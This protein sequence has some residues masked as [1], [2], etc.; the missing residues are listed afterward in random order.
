MGNRRNRSPLQKIGSFLLQILAIIAAIITIVGYAKR[1]VVELTIDIV[2]NAS[3]FDL[4]QELSKLHVI[5]DSV[6]L[7]QN[8]LMLSV[9]LVRFNNT[10]FNNIQKESFDDEFPL[11]VR[12][13]EGRIIERPEIYEASS[14]YLLK[15]FESI[16]FND[17]T[18][19]IPA[20]HFD[21]NE[22][23]SINLLVLHDS[24]TSPTLLATGK[25][26]GQRELKVLYSPVDKENHIGT[27]FSGSIFIHLLR[28]L[29]YVIV[30]AFVVLIWNALKNLYLISEEARDRN[31]LK[32][33]IKAFKMSEHYNGQTAHDYE[34]IFNRYLEPVF[35]FEKLERLYALLND[36]EEL[37]K[38]Y[39]K[40]K[41]FER[42]KK[43][44][45]YML[46]SEMSDKRFFRMLIADGFC[47]NIDD[48]LVPNA[49][50]VS[51]LK[52]FID[53]VQEYGFKI[54]REGARQEAHRLNDLRR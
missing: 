19:T 10:G 35:D 44:H 6:D 28:L 39:N 50:M 13:Q 16:S 49:D 38:R 22:Y 29:L 51:L 30:I 40:S 54:Y 8:D 26:S 42:S 20:V 45:Y 7:K 23:V 25:L 4:N 1:N 41:R 14:E 12:L 24:E 21:R 27:V 52:S 48:R 3:V 43:A 11:G 17:T 36:E 37:N 15:A 32:R 9:V 2:S 18:V 5:Y 46:R 47:Q 31:Q 33:T 53:F 34:P